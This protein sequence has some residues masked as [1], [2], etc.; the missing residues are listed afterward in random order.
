MDD[1]VVATRI[2]SAFSAVHPPTAVLRPVRPAARRRPRFA[3]VAVSAMAVVVIGM[4]VAVSICLTSPCPYGTGCAVVPPTLEPGALTRDEAIA[5]AIRQAPPGMSNPTVE[6]AVDGQNPFAPGG[7]PPVWLVRLD[8]TADIPTCAPG[9]LDR[10]P[11]PSDGPCLGN[12]LGKVPYG[13][14]VVLDPYTGALLGW[15]Q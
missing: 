6:W 15:S 8:G 11:S 14:V 10:V 1:D 4:A 7:S 13:L 12:Q 2:R 9:Y 3:L 5:A